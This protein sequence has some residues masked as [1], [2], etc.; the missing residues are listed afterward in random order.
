MLI[1]AFPELS[2]VEVPCSN[3][4]HVS[5][6]QKKKFT[7]ISYHMNDMPKL[8]LGLL[9]IKGIE[10]IDYRYVGNSSVMFPKA[11]QQGKAM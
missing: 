8:W 2:S 5:K 9:P 10:T 1:N 11:M 3:H 7:L 4:N 6:V